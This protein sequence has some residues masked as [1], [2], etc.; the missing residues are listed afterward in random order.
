MALETGDFRPICVNLRFTRKDSF[1]YQFTLTQ[2]GVAIDLTGS[3]F[4]LT[5]N[6]TADGSGTELFQVAE[7]N[8][9]GVAG[10]VEFLPSVL[11]HTQVVGEYY[12]DVQW[13]DTSANVR[14]VANGAYEFAEEVTS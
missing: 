7:N 4:L 13:T 12:Y 9:P 14:T 3:T 1:P 11:N 2:S 10:I 8:T 6:T 5:V